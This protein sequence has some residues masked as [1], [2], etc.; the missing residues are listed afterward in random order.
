MTARTSAKAINPK[1]YRDLVKRA[2]FED[3]G[4]QGD[5][6]TAAIFGDEQGSARL[7][8]KDSGIAAG[9]EVFEA[10][11]KELDP[12]TTVE[13]KL[14]DGEPVEPGD[15]VAIVRGKAASL[16]A[17]ERVALNFVSYLS[18]IATAARKLSAAAARGGTKILDTR[19]TLPGYRELAKY[20][21]RVGGAENHR[22]GL[23]DMVLIK[24]NH[25]DLAGSIATAVRRVRTKWGD[26]FKIEVECRNLHEVVEALEAKVDMIMLDN[27]QP[28]EFKRAVKLIGG[29][30]KVELSGNM[31]LASVKRLA[32][33][34]VDYISV[35][36]LTHSVRVFDF[37]LKVEAI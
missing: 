5:V 28:R 2:L 27:M 11:F 4:S 1:I 12:A 8:S 15:V 17:A 19:K 30:T 31:D 13:L 35:G 20:A 37:S 26:R 21:V 3:L 36:S 24:D 18:G 6:T 10:V 32:G 7:T 9:L 34:G 22:M 16:L 29:R 14:A 25:I 23:F 33:P